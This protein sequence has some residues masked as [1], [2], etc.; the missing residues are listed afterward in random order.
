MKGAFLLPRHCY[1]IIYGEKERADICSLLDMSAGHVDPDDFDAQKH[2]LQD[3]E[4][5]FS[6]WGSPKLTAEN[7]ALMPKLK[8]Y[9]YGAGT[10]RYIVTDAFWER[11]IPICSAYAANAVPVT[12]FSLSQILY[13][14]KQGWQHAISTRANRKYNRSSSV[15][16]A[17]G[18][19]VGLVSMGMIG[20]MVTARLKTFDVNV[21]AYD[22]FLTPEMAQ[23]LGV[24][25]VSLEEVFERSHVVSLHAPWLPETEKMIRGHHIRS[26]KPSSSLINTARGAVIDETELVEA[27]RE[28]TDVVAVLDV[29]WPEPPPADSPLFDL[30]NI[31][32][33][34]HIAGSMNQECNRMGRLM[35][36]EAERFVNGDP[37]RWSISRERSA[38]MA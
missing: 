21:I 27:L 30:P 5:V 22:P 3:V 1:N 6:G 26:M 36:E 8:A 20:R 18:T 25:S 29:V 24:E 11:N 2:R 32:L 28:R 7:L 15:P 13:C 16:G 10:L 31:V 38:T 23:E 14:L 33:T 12:E 19:T 9:L 4:I 37:L 17:F 35:F 34:P